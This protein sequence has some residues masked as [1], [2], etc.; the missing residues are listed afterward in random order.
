MVEASDSKWV[1]VPERGTR[2]P[3]N[4][5]GNYRGNGEGSRVK[6]HV[7]RRYSCG[8]WS[9]SGVYQASDSKW[10]KVPERGNRRPSNHHGNYRGNGEGSQVK[11]IRR[12]DVPVVD[13]GAQ[14]VSSR[15]YPTQP[16]ED[17]GQQGAPQVTYEEGEITLNG[18][19][20][21]TLPSAEFQMELSTTQAEGSEVIVVAMEEDRGLFAVQGMMEKQDDTFEDIEMELDAINAAM[22]ESGVDLE[23]EE[24]FQTLSEEELEQASEAQVGNAL[25]QDEEQPVT[26]EENINKEVGTG[27]LATRQSHRKRLFK[28]HSS[29]AGSTKMRMAAALVSP[30]RKVVAKVGARHGD[31]TKPPENKGPSIPKP[32]NLK[33]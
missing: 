4:Q 33:F 31:N 7:R 24:E 12:E 26:G 15:T 17:Q 2:R 5:Y 27:D 13:S 20:V 9:S 10:V 23:T 18:D 1:K 11:T 32:V 19:A 3:P 16:R 6:I 29:T 8:L 14:V 21:A 22:I 30:R 25:I 28:P